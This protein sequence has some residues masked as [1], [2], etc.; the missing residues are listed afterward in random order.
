MFTTYLLL[1]LSFAVVEAPTPH[2]FSS[3]TWVCAEIFQWFCPDPLTDSDLFQIEIKNTDIPFLDIG[4]CRDISIVL[5]PSPDSDLFQIEIK[6]TD[7]PF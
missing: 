3:Q 1:L 2:H 6:N 7:N 5:S 4:I